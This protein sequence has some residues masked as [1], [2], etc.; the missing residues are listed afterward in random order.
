[1]S[2]KEA[3]NGDSFDGLNNDS[4]RVNL[5]SSISYENLTNFP[6]F[7]PSSEFQQKKFKKLLLSAAQRHK[8]E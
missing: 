2:R 7:K 6:H 8:N 4:K 1:M 5:L 3:E